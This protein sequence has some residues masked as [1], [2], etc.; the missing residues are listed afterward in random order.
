ML[1]AGLSPDSFLGSAIQLAAD[2]TS[3]ARGI[4]LHLA[5]QLPPHFCRRNLPTRPS[6]A[7]SLPPSLP[8]GRSG[9]HY[10]G[11]HPLNSLWRFDL[12]ART[13]TQLQQTRDTRGKPLPRFEHSYTQVTPP[14]SNGARVGWLAGGGLTGW[15]WSA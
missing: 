15:A 2:T 10:Y 3:S 5:S 12:A 1:L 14:G 4:L 8:A 7:F 6:L 11:S 13:W 9:A